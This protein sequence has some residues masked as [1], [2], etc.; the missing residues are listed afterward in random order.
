MLGPEQFHHCLYFLDLRPLARFVH[1]L[2]F[3]FFNTYSRFAFQV[4]IVTV[5]PTDNN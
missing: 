5:A 4:H 3:F 1:S 2:E